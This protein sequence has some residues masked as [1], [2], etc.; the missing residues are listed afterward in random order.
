MFADIGAAGEEWQV[1][2]AREFGDEA[3]VGIRLLAAQLVVEVGDEEDDAEF[4]AQ[5]EQHAQQGD[6]VGSAGNGNSNA[7]ARAAADCVREC[8]GAPGRARNDGKARSYQPSAFSHG[9]LSR[10]FARI[11]LELVFK[12]Q[13]MIRVNL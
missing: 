2:L 10:G 5:F 11:G 6:G 7:V 1:V 4:L 12:A 13:E 8:S 3:L 9:K